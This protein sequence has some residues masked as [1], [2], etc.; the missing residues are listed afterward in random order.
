[1]DYGLLGGKSLWALHKELYLVSVSHIDLL[2]TSMD[3][4]QVAI[5]LGP[6][7]TFPRAPEEG[8]YDR[9]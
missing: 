9:A 8:V 3:G 7:A 5:L 6:R 1:M 4:N 2:E